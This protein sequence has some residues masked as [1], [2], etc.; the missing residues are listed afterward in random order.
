M[1]ELKQLQAATSLHD[2]AH[3]L[4]VKPGMLSFQLYKKSKS[5]LYTR[6]EIPKRQGGVREILAPESDLKLLQHRLSKLLQK[7]IVEINA[8]HG[9]VESENQQGKLCI[10][11][12]VSM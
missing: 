4:E 7:C 8:T 2:L 9:Y 10:T 12:K 11:P 5:V 3:L 6:F 1:S